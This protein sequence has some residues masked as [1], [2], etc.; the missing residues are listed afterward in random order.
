[1]SIWDTVKK[2]AQPYADEEYDDYDE[3]EYLDEY[4]EEPQQPARRRCPAQEDLGDLQ[5]PAGPKC[6]SKDRERG[7]LRDCFLD[8]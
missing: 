8:L 1:M 6:R 2:F 7:F 4:E 3:E 5:P